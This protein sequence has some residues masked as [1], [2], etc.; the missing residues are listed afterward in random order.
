MT[1][2]RLKALGLIVLGSIALGALSGCSKGK[3]QTVV[4][5]DEA[6]L[7]IADARKA[8]ATLSNSALREAEDKLRQAE[9]SFKKGDYKRARNMASEVTA[10]SVRAKSEAERRAAERRS[11]KGTAK[12]KKR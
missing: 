1:E 5:L 2:N 11:Q 10:S 7:S 6:K 8:G 3:E 4:A 9:D 12:S